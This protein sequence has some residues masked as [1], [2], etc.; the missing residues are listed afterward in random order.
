M[1]E[2]QGIQFAEYLTILQQAGENEGLMD[3]E[4]AEQDE[5][6]PLSVV[7]IMLKAIVEGICRVM[8]EVYP[9]EDL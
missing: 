7:E 6:I 5:W 9:K 4:D 1:Q 3:I 2:A 8:Q